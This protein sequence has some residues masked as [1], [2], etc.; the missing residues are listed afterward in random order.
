MNVVARSLAPL[1]L[2]VPCL[3][4]ACTEP[5]PTGADDS[6][7]TEAKGTVA[8][9]AAWLD[10]ELMS[11]VTVQIRGQAFEGGTVLRPRIVRLVRN[12][13][14]GTLE[15]FDT[16]PAP[17]AGTSFV[18]EKI[19]EVAIAE[20][21]K[22]TISIDLTRAWGGLKVN[23]D[24]D[25]TDDERRFKSF[26]AEFVERDEDGIAIG[27]RAAQA[28]P[29][30]KLVKHLQSKQTTGDLE[31]LLSWQL[32]PYAAIP[33]VP[34][35]P[36]D[37]VKHRYALA[38]DTTKDADGNEIA[39]VPRWNLTRPIAVE[40]D[41]S[42]S[43]EE[44]DDLLFGLAYWEKIL[45]KGAFA[46]PTV[47]RQRHE[48]VVPRL[49][50]L[51]VMKEAAGGTSRGGNMNDPRTGTV[52][53]GQLR[54]DSSW[55]ADPSGMTTRD[56]MILGSIMAGGDGPIPPIAAG[57]QHP[58]RYWMT[59]TAAHEFGHVLGLRHNFAGSIGASFPPSGFD[60][61]VRT[62]FATGSVPVEMVPSGSV[63]DYHYPLNTMINGVFIRDPKTG[64]LD[65]D[66]RA[67]E[68]LYLDRTDGSEVFFCNDD[69][70]AAGKWGCDWADWSGSPLEAATRPIPLGNLVAAAIK[71]AAGI[72]T[73]GK[74]VTTVA[75]GAAAI[76]YKGQF[77]YDHGSRATK[78]F[79]AK[80][81][82]VELLASSGLEATPKS[83]DFLKVELARNSDWAS[84]LTARPS[85]PE[86]A[87]KQVIETM[88]PYLTKQRTAW[89]EAFA[90]PFTDSE[91]DAI[92]EVLENQRTVI[93]AAI[94]ENLVTDL[95]GEA[96]GATQESPVWT[97]DDD[98]GREFARFLTRFVDET[99]FAQAGAP[100]TGTLSTKDG[101]TAELDL[102]KYR[103]S[104]SHRVKMA[105][106]LRKIRWNA[107][108]DGAEMAALSQN[109][110][111]LRAKVVPVDTIDEE[112]T[113]PEVLEW[114]KT[115]NA[116]VA[117]LGGL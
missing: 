77:S 106:S 60:A 102:P 20:E 67:I 19:G 29:T 53:M 25:L 98:G 3:L 108:I 86:G 75:L 5:A 35:R 103:R 97:R 112:R 7:F 59:A 4:S 46:A 38:P 51:R 71:A 49:G 30:K 13:R 76:D 82:A 107:A 57:M 94:F 56:A 100:L 6:S 74:P 92:E 64:V 33:K 114:M 39:F 62:I 48:Q 79:T 91:V 110:A 93:E 55:T 90:I 54:F 44:R 87:L 31:Y 43:N 115:A 11:V 99:V 111:D 83:V 17:F 2:L 69:D 22:E 14:R 104:S 47:L 113:T 116:I 24:V 95:S 12:E 78:F 36:R 117:E 32:Q 27:F 9:P 84:R 1:A 96:A 21:N 66:R 58:T 8:M 70:L 81:A 52:I 45:G 89:T 88:R 50:R 37:A 109:V 73:S 40:L 23:F 42:L 80:A 34:A 41:P 18:P 26:D 63:V 72:K 16:T 85:I 68:A 101:S 15:I 65:W 10:G 61:A 105:S 28:N